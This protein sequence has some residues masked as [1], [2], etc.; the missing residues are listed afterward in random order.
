VQRI[1]REDLRARLDAGTVTLVERLPGPHDA[2]HL[3]G[4]VDLPGQPGG[5]A[6]WAEAGLR[7]DRARAM[8]EAA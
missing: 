7:L 5:R 6:D 2:D 3:P 8:P 1:S 4:A